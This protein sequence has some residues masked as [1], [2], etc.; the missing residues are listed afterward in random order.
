MGDSTQTGLDVFIVSILSI[1]SIPIWLLIYDG[2]KQNNMK[3]G[4]F[5]VILFIVLFLLLSVLINK[6]GIWLA[7]SIPP[8]FLVFIFIIFVKNK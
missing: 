7:V 3:K 6:F 1:S 5:H 8:L 4:I 2:Y